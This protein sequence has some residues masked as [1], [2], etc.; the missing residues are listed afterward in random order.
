MCA[1]LCTVPFNVKGNT[2]ESEA[3]DQF[4]ID[5]HGYWE[6]NPEHFFCVLNRLWCDV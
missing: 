1:V 3:S 2:S 5:P 4:K 6:W